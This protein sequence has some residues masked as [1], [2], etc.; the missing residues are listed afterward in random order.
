[1]RV[2]RK[3][4]WNGDGRAY[5]LCY[6]VEGRVKI[7]GEREWVKEGCTVAGAWKLVYEI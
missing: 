4:G 2:V 6:L 7:V 3:V 5:I 1:M